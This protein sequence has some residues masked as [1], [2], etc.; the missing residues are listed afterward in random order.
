[1]I[2]VPLRVPDDPSIWITV[3]PQGYGGIQWIV[4]NLIDG[5]LHMGY[6]IFL[7][8]APGSL[9]HNPALTVVDVGEPKDIYSWLVQNNIDV[10]HDHS[11]GIV[12]LTELGRP[13]VSTHHLTGSPKIRENAIYSSYAQRDQAGSR[14]A[15]VVRIPINPSRYL[16]RRDKE[17]FLLAL[18]RISPWKGVKE[19]AQFSQAA[20]IPLRIAGP[21]W[22]PEYFEEIFSTYGECVE[23]LGE[24][25]GIE[26][27]TLLANA[28][29]VLVLSQNTDGP[30]GERWC[31]PGATVVSEASVS[32]TPIIS[33][34]NGCLAEITPHVG[35]VITG[36]EPVSKLQAQQIM[37][38]LP[39]PPIVRKTAIKEWGHVKIAQLYSNIYDE[40]I[41]GRQ[42]H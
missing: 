32:G 4:A 30:W 36:S 29:A 9:A 27:L 19:A 23:Y 25:G 15:P 6:K 39:S 2:N 22:E 33:S 20:N 31:E 26:R 28:R 42:W 24:V 13:F 37:A 18:C 35:V 11:N 21:S 41:K 34:D 12:P 10:I 40:V 38:G 17:N 7:L 3:P 8:G 14:E 16:Y 1:M 5:L